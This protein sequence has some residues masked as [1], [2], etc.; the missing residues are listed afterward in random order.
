MVQTITNACLIIDDDEVQNSWKLFLFF[1][2]LQKPV[3]LKEE[4]K[5]QQ[6]IE[7]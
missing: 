4:T 7:P 3:G 2:A 6:Y 5:Q 1:C